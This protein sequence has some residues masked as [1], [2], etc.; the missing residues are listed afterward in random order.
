MSQYGPIEEKLNV[1]THFIGLILSLAALPLLIKSAGSGGQLLHIF[2]AAL[3]GAS[4]VILYAASTVYHSTQK[5]GL[6]DRMETVDHASIFVLIAGSYTPFVLVV[7]DGSMRFWMF[8]IVWGLAIAGILFKFVSEGKYKK[9]SVIA[10]ISMGLLSLFIIEP[11][12][13]EIYF[14]GLVWLGVGG[15]SYLIGAALYGT[16][17]LP[18]N[19][20]VFHALI[21]FGS[22]SH[23]MAIYYYI[24]VY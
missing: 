10:Y 9:V 11:I 13:K 12:I 20:S 24:F 14:G 5:Q 18:Y 6:R 23:F 16:K 19:H 17:P 3:Y 8:G 15:A 1:I 21:L 2:S 22:I 7:L 4:A